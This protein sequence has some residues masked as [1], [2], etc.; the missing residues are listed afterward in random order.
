MSNPISPERSVGIRVATAMFQMGIEGLPRNY[1]LVY[2]AY[3]GQNSDLTKEFVAIG[4]AKSQRALDELGRKYLPHHHEDTVL[5]K[6]SDHM[7]HQMASF[8]D[9]L[10]EEKIS[11]NDYGKIIDQASRSI[12]VEGEIDRETLVKS[13][14]Q[15]SAATEQQT[16]KSEAMAAEA[17]QQAQSLESVKSEIDNFE[18][19]K[20]VDQL[21]GLANRRSFNKAIAK[22]YA[23]P[24]LPMMCGLGF[25]EIDGFKSLIASGESGG[26]DGITGDHF[27]RHVGKLLHEVNK[28]GEFVARLDKD[29]FAFLVNSADESEIM[30]VI[31]AL[32][33]GVASRPLISQKNG[34]S[35]GNATLSVG[36]AMSGL[37]NSPAQLMDF[38]EKAMRMSSKSGG[39]RAT[40]Y[41]D[42]APAGAS[43]D[44]MIYRP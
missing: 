6:T 4:K 5:S 25:A 27:I 22:V 38:A 16:S 19:M 1:E 15:L 3:S 14:Q 20:F 36:V 12:S 21:T 41:S 33:V 37:A 40:L 8:I 24:D 2:E 30:R 42:K 18:R 26:G 17:Q 13:I 34:R 10:E 43:R 35:L 7:R 44:W 28:N 32:R 39:N 11:L 9:L 31:D 23:N 29:R